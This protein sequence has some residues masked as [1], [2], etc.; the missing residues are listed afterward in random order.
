MYASLQKNVHPTTC[1]KA[2]VAAKT[3]DFAFLS[4]SAAKGQIVQEMSIAIATLFVKVE[5]V[6]H[7]RIAQEGMRG[8]MVVCVFQ[9]LYARKMMIVSI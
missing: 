6:K 9:L 5:S 2:D 1:A 4:D 8:A 7:M 3:R